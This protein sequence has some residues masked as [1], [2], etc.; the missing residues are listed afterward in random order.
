MKIFKNKINSRRN[1]RYVYKYVELCAVYYKLYLMKTRLKLDS[2]HM[3]IWPCSAKDTGQRPSLRNIRSF[4][5]ASALTASASCEDSKK[6]QGPEQGLLSQ[7]GVAALQEEKNLSL[8]PRP[9]GPSS[10]CDLGTGN[11]QVLA[12]AAFFF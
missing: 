12:E 8:L 10:A 9:T 11:R 6:Q 1:K 5:L 2:L 4:S 7:K 3:A